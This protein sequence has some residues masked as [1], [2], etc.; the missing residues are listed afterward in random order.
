MS[1]LLSQ[2]VEVSIKWVPRIFNGVAHTLAKW[3]HNIFGSFDVGCCPPC[4]E[5]I[6]KVEASS[7]T[8][9]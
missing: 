7:L 9:L 5:S 1:L 3:S 6:I 8:S 2:F 4:F